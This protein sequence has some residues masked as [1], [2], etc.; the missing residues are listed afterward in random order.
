VALS[1]DTV[2]C[3]P[4]YRLQQPQAYYPLAYLKFC[5][6]TYPP[7]EATCRASLNQHILHQTARTE[8]ATVETA[9]DYMELHMTKTEM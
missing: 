5:S 4:G 6:L 3:M 2:Y 7:P 1:V 9:P 8:M